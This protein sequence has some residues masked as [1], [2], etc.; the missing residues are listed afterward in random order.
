LD[1]SSNKGFPSS[2]AL[3]VKRL[4]V[5]GATMPHDASRRRAGGTTM[6]INRPRARGAAS[7]LDMKPN[8]LPGKILHGLVAV[9]LLWAIADAI[10]G[11]LIG[12]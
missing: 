4:T 8:S 5:G 12:G 6:A 9:L 10:K 7:E 1:P 2:R 3:H 11:L